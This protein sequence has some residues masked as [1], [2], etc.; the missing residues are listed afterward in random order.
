[1]A[2]PRKLTHDDLWGFKDVG[3]V[4]LS[5]DGKTLA[6]VRIN[7]E[8]EKNE[9][10]SS[11]WLLSLDE[12]GQASGEPRKLTS[13]IKSDSNPV[14]APDSRRLLFLSSREE[15]KNQLWLIDTQG[16]EARKL[17]NMLHGA[18]DAAW[19]PDGQWIAFAALAAPTDEDDIL[20]GRKPL[21]S[22][23]R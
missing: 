21:G 16:G 20:T 22:E 15:D 4:T 18:V 11:I 3:K 6:F 2:V 12:Q 10:C 19:S 14:W 17:T 5:P 1:M 8:K 23:A 9:W 13:G 7:A